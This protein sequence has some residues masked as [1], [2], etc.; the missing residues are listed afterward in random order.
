MTPAD[1]QIPASVNTSYSQKRECDSSTRLTKKS[2]LISL[3]HPFERSHAGNVEMKRVIRLI[4]C[5]THSVYHSTETN[6]KRILLK[7][8][9]RTVIMRS[10][11]QLLTHGT[12]TYSVKSTS[13]PL[14]SRLREDAAKTD[15]VEL[16]FK[17]MVEYSRGDLFAPPPPIPLRKS[18]RNQE[19]HIIESAEYVR[20]QLTCLMA[21]I[22]I[23]FQNL[24]YGVGNNQRIGQIMQTYVDSYATIKQLPKIKSR[25]DRDLFH[26]SLQ[27]HL[28][29]WTQ[30]VVPKLCIGVLEM[31][32]EQSIQK[33]EQCPYLS[34]FVDRI[35]TRRLAA[36]I[37]AAHYIALDD[38]G[39]G[40]LEEN[41]DAVHHIQIAKDNAL[42][43][44]NRVYKDDE[45]VLPPIT[46]I[47]QT[48]K[49]RENEF[50]F[51]PKIVHQ[52]ALELIKNSI[53][54]TM[55]YHG[56]QAVDNGINVIVC[57]SNDGSVSI[58][59]EDKGG[60]IPRNEEDKIWLY[61][62]T[63][64][65]YRSNNNGSSKP[66]IEVLGDMT[67]INK[68]SITQN[69]YHI[70]AIFQEN[71]PMFGL[72]YGLPLVNAYSQYFGGSCRIHSM[73]GYGTDAYL[74]LPTL[75]TSQSSVL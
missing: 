67:Q 1:W 64:H 26:D 56:A 32:K 8:Q 65:R 12:R 38:H 10:S 28:A 16:S 19:A 75:A 14:L 51:L 35:I 6:T 4:R 40:I 59:I 45:M 43:I 9:K 36:R 34:N 21:R 49:N 17:D 22:I 44:A 47:D 70:G 25:K 57:N 69:P 52:L 61:S 31:T 71:V 20:K 58:K 15:L 62:Y 53:R 54:A 18:K 55:E 30:T 72:G 24:P 66:Q 2:F 60:G 50:I 41:C 42:I 68:L 48:K 23:D 33:I 29:A 27:D 3:Y 63:Q 74:F 7:Y 37:L 5:C 73:A 11:S 39:W 46:V 13:N